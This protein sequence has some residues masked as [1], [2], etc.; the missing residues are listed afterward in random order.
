MIDCE[1]TPHFVLDT[2]Y[3]QHL[4][5]VRPDGKVV[6]VPLG[7]AQGGLQMGRHGNA[8]PSLS[9]TSRD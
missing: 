6:L 4:F 7:E 8:I 2:T 1:M 5:G 9:S 3:A